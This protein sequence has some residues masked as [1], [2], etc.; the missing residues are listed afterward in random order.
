MPIAGDDA[1]ISSGGGWAPRETA[2]AG[3]AGVSIG[4]GGEE[5]GGNSNGGSGGKVGAVAGGGAANGTSPVTTGPDA[6]WVGISM[7]ATTAARPAAT[8]TMMIS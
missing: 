7:S 4:T 8:M 3:V 5:S 6:E 1:S 2:A